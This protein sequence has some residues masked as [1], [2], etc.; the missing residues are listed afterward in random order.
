MS[1]PLKIN[2]IMNNER[3]LNYFQKK[4]GL[5]KHF[6]NGY[7]YWQDLFIVSLTNN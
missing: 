4:C 3:W 7:E 6:K 2:N 5:K 1:V